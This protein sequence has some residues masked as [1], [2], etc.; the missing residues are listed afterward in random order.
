FIR[1]APKLGHQFIAPVEVLNDCLSPEIE[2]NTQSSSRRQ[3]LA[4]LLAVA[5]LGLLVFLG[6]ELRSHQRPTL[7]IVAVA[8]FEE[9]RGDRAPVCSIDL[10][11]PLQRPKTALP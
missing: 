6:Y 11:P 9:G 3:R 10:F 4:S 5:A 2:S 7:P 1:T 8:R